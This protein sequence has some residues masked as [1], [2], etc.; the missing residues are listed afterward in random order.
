LGGTRAARSG[1]AAAIRRRE[2]EVP[3]ERGHD[4]AV[5]SNVANGLDAQDFG[6]SVAEELFRLLP[7]GRLIAASA[8]R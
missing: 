6:V 3:L 4:L 7:D 1:E 5:P 8:A 2:L